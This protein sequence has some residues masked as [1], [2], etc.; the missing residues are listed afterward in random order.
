MIFDFKIILLLISH[1]YTTYNIVPLILDPNSHKSSMMKV[2]SYGFW[3]N[4]GRERKN[5]PIQG[6]GKIKEGCIYRHEC[7]VQKIVEFF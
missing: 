3:E 4:K 7:I 1:H 2:F 6:M 5:E